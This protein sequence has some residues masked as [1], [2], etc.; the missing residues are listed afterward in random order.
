M[1]DTRRTSGIRAVSESSIVQ[2]AADQSVAADDRCYGQ[3]RALS[4][5]P[6]RLDGSGTPEQPAQNAARRVAIPLPTYAT[7][8]ISSTG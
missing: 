8:M 7:P 2:L 4:S 3:F 5:L 1:E 6:L